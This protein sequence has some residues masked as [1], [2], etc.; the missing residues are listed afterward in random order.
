MFKNLPDILSIKEVA[1]ALGI[2]QK[3]AYALVN[4]HRLGCIH[5]GRII[6][7][8]KFCLVEYVRTSRN[9]IRL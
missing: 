1:K 5:I 7:V 3:A 4:E 2:G 8:P 6:K 9:N